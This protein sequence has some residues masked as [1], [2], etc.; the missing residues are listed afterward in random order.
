MDVKNPNQLFAELSKERD[1]ESQAPNPNGS[2]SL[3]SRFFHSAYKQPYPWAPLIV[4]YVWYA[5]NILL[6]G[7][8]VSFPF[9]RVI[10]LELKGEDQ[11][12]LLNYTIKQ[13]ELV[14]PNSTQNL[15]SMIPDDWTPRS[16]HYEYYVKGVCVREEGKQRAC[17][18]GFGERYSAGIMDN[19]GRQIAEHLNDASLAS[20]WSTAYRSSL[21][22][23]HQKFRYPHNSTERF[24]EDAFE[25]ST[26][27]DAIGWP[28]AALCIF[29]LDFI[30]DALSFTSVKYCEWFS[31]ARASIMA[32]FMAFN[33]Y[34]LLAVQ[35]RI[36]FN[37]I[38]SVGLKYARGPYFRLVLSMFFLRFPYLGAILWYHGV[39][40]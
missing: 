37:P 17:Y 8:I 25:D 5:L 30:I 10:K 14:A 29:V 4:Y 32:T 24:I 2:S 31:V 38:G 35:L 22:Q 6:L 13:F 3:I 27:T 9:F 33:F 20:K 15:S 36:S 21:N 12:K 26:S 1:L 23:A 39:P 18:E 19:L 34:F 28:I 16:A 40:L 11:S 7:S